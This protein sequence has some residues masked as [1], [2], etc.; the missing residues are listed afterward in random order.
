MIHSQAK[1]GRL[2]AWILN[3]DQSW[4]DDE[5]QDEHS[6]FDREKYATSDPCSR[7]KS[8]FLD[9]YVLI[10]CYILQKKSDQSVALFLRDI[11]FRTEMYMFDLHPVPRRHKHPVGDFT[12]TYGVSYI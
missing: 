11:F 10:K 1:P 5:V 12:S 3:M 7:L 2:V 4:S 6:I 8:F 9:N